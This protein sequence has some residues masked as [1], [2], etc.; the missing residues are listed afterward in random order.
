MTQSD[1]SSSKMVH[2][3][4]PFRPRGCDDSGFL[5]RGEGMAMGDGGWQGRMGEGEC[6]K[7]C[8]CCG[9]PFSASISHVTL[10]SMYIHWRDWFSSGRNGGRRF[11][12]LEV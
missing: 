9:C 1:I 7:C 8:K 11:C 6:C 2:A 10:C 5:I 12:R 4:G 3:G